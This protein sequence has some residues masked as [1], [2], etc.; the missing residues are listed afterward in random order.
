M[1]GPRPAVR[2]NCEC[3][4]CL[5]P[6]LWLLQC[7]YCQGSHFPKYQKHG[8]GRQARA[9]ENMCMHMADTSLWPPWCIRHR[10]A[11]LRSLSGEVQDWSDTQTLPLLHKPTHPEAFPGEADGHPGHVMCCSGAGKG[12]AVIP[13]SLWEQK[14]NL[15]TFNSDPLFL[16]PLVNSGGLSVL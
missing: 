11:Q 7:D 14:P 6:P 9:Q 12:A 1:Q 2:I 3:T 5:C 4:Q 13:P 8:F 10:S 16:L 15:T